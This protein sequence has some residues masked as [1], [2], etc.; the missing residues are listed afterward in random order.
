MSTNDILRKYLDILNESD[1]APAVAPVTDN[2]ADQ[3]TYAPPAGN[4][5]I[6]KVIE[7]VKEFQEEVGIA[8]DGVITPRTLAEIL[9]QSGAMGKEEMEKLKAA[10]AEQD[11]A[12]VAEGIEGRGKH[13]MLADKAALHLGFAHGLM[14]EAHQCAHPVGSSAHS[15]YAHGHQEGL[16][17]CGAIPGGASPTM[18]SAPAQAAF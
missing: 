7:A 18:P 8:P 16:K 9:S 12:V 14:G 5:S 2:P 15:H 6:K 17:E 3:I 11:P 4:G 10:P 13:D 1:A